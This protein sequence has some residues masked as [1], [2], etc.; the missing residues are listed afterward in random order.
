MRASRCPRKITLL[1]D[2]GY[3]VTWDCGAVKVG[4]RQTGD[5]DAAWEYVDME[6]LA[7]EVGTWHQH[8]LHVP[9]HRVKDS[10]SHIEGSNL[11]H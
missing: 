11:S 6:F 9:H 3:R 4:G 1:A 2:G 5:I 10:K 7:T 8:R